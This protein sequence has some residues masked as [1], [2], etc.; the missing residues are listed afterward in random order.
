MRRWWCTAKIEVSV[1]AYDQ[2]SAERELIDE[3]E[4][5]HENN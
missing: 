4:Y 3:I 1:R 2:S 5:L